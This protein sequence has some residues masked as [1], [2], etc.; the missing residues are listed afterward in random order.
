MPKVLSA[1]VAPAHRLLC[2]RSPQGPLRGATRGLGAHTAECLCRARAAYLGSCRAAGGWGAPFMSARPAGARLLR[3]SCF[4]AATPA[5]WYSCR[6]CSAIRPRSPT[7]RTFSRSSE[8][9]HRSGASAGCSVSVLQ[10]KFWKIYLEQEQ[11]ILKTQ[12]TEHATILA[13]ENGKSFFKGSHPK[14]HYTPAIKD[15]Q[16]ISSLYTF[17]PKEQYYSIL[18]KYVNRSEKR[19]SIRSAEGDALFPILAFVD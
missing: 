11:K 12:A 13:E 16:Q 6:W 2:A 10:L 14:K 1:H 17:N 19:Q 7:C 9:T 15:W 8:L 5:T 18:H 3:G 4:R